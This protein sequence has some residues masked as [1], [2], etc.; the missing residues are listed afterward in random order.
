MAKS[1]NAPLFLLS[2]S[3]EFS[4]TLK[5]QQPQWIISSCFSPNMD[6]LLHRF[7]GRIYVGL[8]ISFFKVIYFYPS[9]R[10]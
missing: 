7:I 4:L 9:W 2:F 8:K 5:K 6:H 10:K 3:L 1:K